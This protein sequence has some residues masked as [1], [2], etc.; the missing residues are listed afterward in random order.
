MKYVGYDFEV[1]GGDLIFDEELDAAVFLKRHGFKDGGWVYFENRNGI[2]VLV[3]TDQV[4]DNPYQTTLNFLQPQCIIGTMTLKNKIDY[5]ELENS[6]RIFKSAT[7][8]YTLDW[9]IKWIASIFV[10]AAI[11][12]RG[13]DGFQF[14]DLSLSVIGVGLWL[15]V[16]ILW[17]DRALILLNGVGLLFLLRNLF[18]VFF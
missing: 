11:S 1:K 8:K 3:C 12:M 18:E 6:K 13:I 10:L 7:P 14:Y 15:W 16:S 4:E 17:Q 5:K 9:Y 2:L